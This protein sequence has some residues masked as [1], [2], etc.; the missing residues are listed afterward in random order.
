MNPRTNPYA[1]GA[2]SLPPELAGRD[3][4]IERAS[5]NLDRLKNG[6][7]ARSVVLYG[8]RG[9]GKTVLLNTIVR[10]AES[11]GFTAVALEA[12]EDRPLPNALI[13]PLHA[14]LRKLSLGARAADFVTA[15]KRKLVGFAR[16]FKVKYE[17][18]DFELDLDPLSGDLEFDL[19]E[20]F[21][22]L[23][24]AAKAK[25]T[26]LLISI[27]ELQ[28]VKENELRAL[29]GALHQ[30]SQRQLPVFVVAAGLPQLAGQ[31]GEA[32]SYAER[33]FALQEIGP[34]NRQAA[35]DALCKPAA[36]SDV[37]F[38]TA[39]IDRILSETKGYPYFI[40]E[41]GRH[42]WNEAAASPISSVIADR[43]TELALMELD[44]SFFRMRLD[45]LTPVERRYLRAMADLGP[46][47]H[48]S[49]DIAMYLKK[50][51]TSVAPTRSSLI[52]KG[53]I[54]SPNHG[55]T[56]FTVPLFDAYMKR[57]VVV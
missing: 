57:I 45:R 7:Q 12:P 56:A 19:G 37:A 35:I 1:P 55:D 36:R 50:K 30:M 16:A 3:D 2:G 43:A 9:V 33:L 51:V 13:P 44:Q 38:D 32:K 47:P 26:A 46:G 22:A 48:R 8:L 5:I 6:F 14:A 28:Y 34:L 49:G 11:S 42:C 40:Q 31:M 39:A 21:T 41:W 15:A 29:I 10:A 20:L 18:F 17:G 54:Y 24:E 23:G 53:M 4:I 52:S 27:D 25:S